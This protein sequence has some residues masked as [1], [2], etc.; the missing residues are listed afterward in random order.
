MG[1]PVPPGLPL[2]LHACVDAQSV[3]SGITAENV[4]VSTERHTLHHAQWV[5]ELCEKELLHGLW[6]VDTR[7]CVGDG[8]TKGAVARQHVMAVMDGLWQVRHTA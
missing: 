2:E 4:K 3:F 1:R 5:R 6:W 7:D 8:L